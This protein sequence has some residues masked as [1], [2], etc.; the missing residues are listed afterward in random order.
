MRRRL[1]VELVRRQIVTTRAEAQQAILDGLVTVDGA[2]AL[3]PGT[4]VA[5]SQAV[6]LK[7]PARRFASRG[8]EKLAHA[9]AVFP[10]DI[11][12]RSCLDAGASTGGFTDVLLQHGA[13]EVWAFDVGYGQIHERLRQDPRVHVRERVNVREITPE[14]LEGAVPEVL[15]ADLSFVSLTKV[16]G[17]LKQ[18]TAPDAQAIVLVK[19][20]FE[21]GRDQVQRGGVVRDP[22]VWQRVI[23]EV[24]T[25]AVSLG[26]A[27]YG[28]TT[29]PIT[30]P[31][32]NVEFLLHLGPPTQERLADTGWQ[33]AVEQAVRDGRT[34][35]AKH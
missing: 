19:P 4:Q 31:K 21:A 13:R 30:G 10:I 1:D 22:D 24:I 26:W 6:S 3:K 27:C 12:E 5:A 18:V 16:L 2:P 33:D 11:A 34:V 17:A 28:I 7:R 14:H 25:H 20:Q 32:G 15:V 8:G 23:G 35:R 9:L 29:S